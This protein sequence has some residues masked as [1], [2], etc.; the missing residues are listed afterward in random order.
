VIGTDRGVEA[1]AE[2][3]EWTGEEHTTQHRDDDLAVVGSFTSDDA[4][5]QPVEA[6]SDALLWVWGSVFGFE[7]DDGYRPRT[8]GDDRTAS[9]CASL[10]DRHG[11]EFVAGLNGDFVGILYDQRDRTVSVFTDRLGLRDAYYVGPRDDVLVFSTAIQS[12]S[13]HP[14]VRPAFD[15][16][17]VVEYFSS[18]FRT[19]GLRTP[20]AG[21]SMFPPA[22]VVS[23]DIPTTTVK[24]RRYWT[25]QYRPRDRS[26]SYFLDEFSRRFEAAVTERLRSGRDY[27]LCLSGGADSRLVLA[28]VDPDLR[29]NLTAYHCAGWRSREARIAEQVARTAGVTFDLLRRGADYHER[30]LERNPKLS[31]FVGTFEQAHLEGFMPEIRTSVDE[32]LT[33]SFADSNFK[34]YSFPRYSFELGQLGTIRLPMLE[35]MDSIDRYVD[36]WVADPPEFLRT[37]VDPE[38]VMRAEIRSTGS[39]VDHHGVTYGSPVELFT[40]GML[41]P[42]TNGSVLFMLQSLRQHLPAWSPFVDNRLVDLYLSMPRRYF[43]RR[44][45]VLRAVE[46]LDPDLA[47][48]RYANSGMPVRYPLPAHLLAEHCLEFVDKHLQ[49]NEPPAPHLSQGPWPDIPELIRTRSFVADAIREHE[50]LIRALPFLEWDGVREC[51]RDHLAGSNNASDLYGLLTLLEMPVTRRIADET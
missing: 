33:A 36:F 51:Y 43:V 34:A 6:G 24:S 50:D 12:L 17:Y 47:D 13:R 39:G 23:V 27:G 11:I 48:I 38:A 42:R 2:G 46:R 45:V 15:E 9:Y 26:F 28:A 21:T 16:R 8:P 22:S 30:A 32:M 1:V 41:T 7:G 5:G 10:Y 19:F 18:H 37:D 25:P 40:C 29:E 35:P 14:D 31:N 20:L 49:V 4:G 3:L 44:N